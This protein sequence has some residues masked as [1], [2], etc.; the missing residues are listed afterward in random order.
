[1]KSDEGRGLLVGRFQ[2]F[3]LG[4]LQCVLYVLKKLPQIII[5]IGS[6]QFSHTL[7]NPFTAGERVT[8]IRLA[9]D[10][11]KIDA[12]KYY[13]IPVRDLR[14][15]DLW[16]SHLIS[17]TPRF[18]VVFSNEPI[19]SRLFKEAGFRVEPIPYYDRETYSST[20]IRER[21]LQGEDWEKLV[22]SS[23]AAYIKAVFGD[24]RLRELAQS[25][26]PRQYQRRGDHRF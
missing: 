7:H 22:P 24:E 18:E 2:P 1:L 4:H 16:V 23:I 12:S 9:L 21:V 15:H 26:S 13:L 6:A 14:I 8:M 3:H 5:A 20:E 19:T 10:E 17:Q 25:D 11:A